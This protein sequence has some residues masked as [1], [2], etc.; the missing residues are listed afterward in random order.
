MLQKKLKL[1]T[2]KGTAPNFGLKNGSLLLTFSGEGGILSLMYIC[3][4]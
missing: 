4:F 3:I 1:K 2:E